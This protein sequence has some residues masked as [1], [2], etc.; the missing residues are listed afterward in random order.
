MRRLAAPHEPPAVKRAVLDP[1]LDGL[2]RCD[3]APAGVDAP[4]CPA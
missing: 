3:A 1:D 2:H 4:P